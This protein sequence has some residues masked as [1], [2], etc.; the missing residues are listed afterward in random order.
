[1]EHCQQMAGMLQGV[2]SS[3]TAEDDARIA[4]ILEAVW[5]LV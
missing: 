5:S 4:D 2:R 1:M 3:A